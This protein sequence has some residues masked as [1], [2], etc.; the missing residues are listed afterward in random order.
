[1]YDIRF[2]KFLNFKLGT[3]SF[4]IH[5]HFRSSTYC[6]LYKDNM[7]I[8]THHRIISDLTAPIEI[9]GQRYHIK[10]KKIN[11]W[12]GKEVHLACKLTKSLNRCKRC[13]SLVFSILLT[14]C[15]QKT[16]SRVWFNKGKE[17]KETIAVVIDLNHLTSPI[18]ASQINTLVQKRQADDLYNEGCRYAAGIHVPQ[19]MGRANNYFEHASRK[20]NVSAAVALGCFYLK[21]GRISDMNQARHFFAI[22]ARAIT[23]AAD[24]VYAAHQLGLLHQKGLGGEVD[25]DK[26]IDYLEKAILGKRNE[27]LDDAYVIGCQYKNG[28]GVSVE[29]TIA[30]K[31]FT[32]AGLNGHADAAVEAGQMYLAG[33]GGGQDFVQARAFLDLG[34]Q[35]SAYSR[36]DAACQLAGMYQQGLGGSVDHDTAIDY[37]DNAIRWGRPKM[38]EDA[39]QLGCQYKNG[40]GAVYD[41]TVARKYFQLAAYKLHADAATELGQMYLKGLGGL[42]QNFDLARAFL[43][44]G[45]KG[46][47][48]IA[49][50]ELAKMFQ[51]GLGVKVSHDIAIIH[52]GTACTRG[53]CEA[54]D[55]AYTYAVGHKHDHT[56]ARKYFAFAGINGH[57]DAALEAGYMY[58]KGLGVIKNLDQ[59]NVFFG[60]ARF[61]FEANL[62][63]T[64]R[65]AYAAHQLGMLYQK[66]LGGDVDHEKAIEYLEKAIL[67]GRQE[68]I[69][70]AYEVGIQY[71]YGHGEGVNLKIARK[72]LTIAGRNRHALA[73]IEAGLMYYKGQGKSDSQDLDM[74][75]RAART[76]L[77]F[78]IK[79]PAQGT[80]SAIHSLG[81]LHQK[82][83]GGSAAHYLARLYQKGLGGSV[84][85]EKAIEYFEKAIVW[86]RHEVLD[87]VCLIGDQYKKGMDVA[88]DLTV[89][90]KYFTLAGLNGHADAAAEAGQMSYEGLGGDLN[91]TVARNFF[92]RGT[93]THALRRFESAHQLAIM[94]QKG[95]GGDVDHDKAIACLTRLISWGGS[96]TVEEAYQIGYQYKN[97]TEEIPIDLTVARKYFE[98]AAQKGHADA[99]GQL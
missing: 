58:S 46:H 36:V 7:K 79:T 47:N 51:T 32:L 64:N 41:L 87:E 52:L 2:Y 16:A 39:Y 76:F 60:K 33:Q 43:T 81:P 56:I 55:Y 92:I 68:A 67:W 23:P 24:V 57:A 12:H 22:G 61:L 40:T 90:R 89:A 82:Q 1:M 71:K 49:S 65:R 29:P 53:S 63:S 84:D 27:A 6:A 31:Y 54:L 42:P 66:G 19:D 13:C 17:G 50:L 18:L 72:Y 30:R 4:T 20:G 91:L 69:D 75:L 62:G 70:E 8:R 44:E 83:V 45:E 94:Y 37:L 93:Q 11:T 73:A 38:V 35:G 85:H 10:T 9:N 97:G 88:V 77:D 3:G 26:A 80:G 95:L 74:D 86:G 78:G 96:K 98:L 34:V 5:L 25:H 48:T 14:L 21:G 59:A 28:T 15:F 99:A